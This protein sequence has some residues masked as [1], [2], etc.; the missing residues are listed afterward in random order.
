MVQTRLSA[1]NYKYSTTLR[2]ISP[3]MIKML[4]VVTESRLF[5]LSPLVLGSILLLFADRVDAATFGR[6][7]R[8]RM[9]NQRSFLIRNQSGRRADIL[10]VDTSKE[11]HEFVS[12]STDDDGYLYGS[13]TSISSYIGH[14]FEIRELPSKK[15][16]RCVYDECRKARFKV[17]DQENQQIIVDKD[18]VVTHE[19]DRQRAVSSAR[20]LYE[21][22][23]SSADGLSLVEAIEAIAVCMEAQVN[24]TLAVQ[25]EERDFQFALREEMARDLIPYACGDVN[26]TKGQETH[27]QSWHYKDGG[28]K[29][30][31]YDLRMMHERPTSVIFVVDNFATKEDCHALK[32]YNQDNKVPFLSI[33]EKTVQGTR[34]FHLA[35]KMYELGK[36]ALSWNNLDFLDTH[37][38]GYP[39]FEVLKDEVGVDAP[40]KLCVGGESETFT[41]CR[42]PGAEPFAVTTKSVVVENPSQLA[43]AFLFCDEPE[44]LGALHF[45]LAGV[46]V[47]PKVGKLVM[48]I[49]RFAANTELDKY[50][51]EYYLCPNHNVYVHTFVEKA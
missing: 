31:E 43:N 47:T 36:V 33:S 34:L 30:T 50:V 29:Y 26:F 27:N 40:T 19:D 13:D 35:T 48:S 18:Y 38:M 14:E 51:S 25:E 22:C 2:N 28:D 39:L 11:P 24:A 20:T 16:G 37:Q 6:Q 7:G 1:A 45:P 41:K 17:N 23:K 21:K 8:R 15:T 3:N 9:A 42:L 46:H 4:P 44:S 5:L 49:N 32:A 12:Q 10:W